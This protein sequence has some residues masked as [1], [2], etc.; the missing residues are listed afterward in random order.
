[1]KRNFSVHARTTEKEYRALDMIAMH[2]NIN[3]SE[4]IR[5]LIHN[6]CGRRGMPVGLVE[7][8]KELPDQTAVEVK[9]EQPD[10][11]R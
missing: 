11:R 2:E 4:A 9:N 7:F 5:L 3:P 6:E 1:M 8:Y 10:P